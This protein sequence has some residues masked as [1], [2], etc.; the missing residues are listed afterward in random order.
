VSER[1]QF[2]PSEKAKIADPAAPLE[3]YTTVPAPAAEAD[4]AFATVYVGTMMSPTKPFVEITGPVNVVLAIL[5]P[6][7]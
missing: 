4:G 7:A 5:V 1:F 6:F 2:V 3:T